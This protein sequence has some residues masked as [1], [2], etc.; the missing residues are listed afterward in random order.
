MSRPVG[1][2]PDGMTVM[3]DSNIFVYALLPQSSLHVHCKALLEWGAMGR[4][5]LVTIVAVAA[6]LLHRL[7]VLEVLADGRAPTSAAAVTL[8]KHEP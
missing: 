5:R 1:E 6:Y 4:L 8:L 2:I 3:V 7:M